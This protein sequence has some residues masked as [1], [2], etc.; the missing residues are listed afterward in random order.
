MKSAE[1]TASGRVEWSRIRKLKRA[2]AATVEFLEERRMMWGGGSGTLDQL[3]SSGTTGS[4][5]GGTMVSATP[6]YQSHTSTSG[7]GNVSIKVDLKNRDVTVGLPGLNTLLSDG[8]SSTTAA[9]SSLPPTSSIWWSSAAGLGNFYEDSG[10]PVGFSL[11]GLP[12]LGISS[13]NQSGRPVMLTVYDGN[14]YYSYDNVNTTDNFVP[15]GDDTARI[16]KLTVASRDFT[17]SSTPSGT[18]AYYI[19]E[20]GDGTRVYFDASSGAYRGQTDEYGNET[21]VVIRSSGDHEILEVNRRDGGL[22]ST[23]LEQTTFSY[24]GSWNLL[25]SKAF[26]RLQS[27]TLTEYQRLDFT[28]YQGNDSTGATNGYRG[29]LKLINLVRGGQ[30]VDSIYFRYHAEPTELGYYDEATDTY[31]H[32][33][34]MVFDQDAY[35]RLVADHPSDYDSG[36]LW[37]YSTYATTVFNYSGADIESVVTAGEGAYHDGTGTGQGTTTYTF[38]A[39]P[40]IG[41]APYGVNQPI[42]VVTIVTPDGTQTF[43]YLNAAGQILIE[44]VWN[45]VSDTN[46]STADTDRRDWITAYDYDANSRLIRVASP[47][48]VTRLL[49]GSY[50]GS[51]AFFK[52]SDSFAVDGVKNSA[53]VV[54][55]ATGRVDVY[56][57][58]SGTIGSDTPYNLVSAVKLSQG[59]NSST[60]STSEMT[61]VARTITDGNSNTFHAFLTSSVT[62]YP[63]EGSTSGARLTSN[64]YTFGSGSL[65]PSRVVVSAPSVSSSENGK[66]S[67]F[68]YTYDYNSLGLLTS[69]VDGENRTNTF[70]YDNPTRAILTSTVDAGGLALKTTYERDLFGRATKIV[71]PRY[72]GL[73][74]TNTYATFYVYDDAAHTVKTYE[75]WR[76]G[77]SNGYSGIGPVQMYRI[78]RARGYSEW[79]TY[80]PDL[81]SAYN[82]LTYTPTGTESISNIQSLVR[83]VRNTAQQV[84]SI[85]RYFTLTGTTYTNTSA[86]FGSSTTNYHSTTYGYDAYGRLDRTTLSTGTIYQTVYDLLGRVSEEKIGT[87]LANSRTTAVYQYDLGQAGNSLLTASIRYT[88]YNGSGVPD[89]DAARATE[90]GYDWRDRLVWK[91]EGSRLDTGGSTF[92]LLPAQESNA[93]TGTVWIEQLAYHRPITYYTYNNLDQVTATEMFDGDTQAISYS[94]GVPVKPSSGLLTAKS[95]YEYDAMGQLYRSSSWPVDGSGNVGTYAL[96]SDYWYDSLGNVLQ[97]KTPD[98]AAWK[99]TYD[100]AG[101]VTNAYAVLPGDADNSIFGTSVVAGSTVLEQYTYEYDK[102]SNLTLVTVRQRFHDASG[103]GALGT[104]ASTTSPK[105]RVSYTQYFYDP[106]SRLTDKVEVGTNGG[107]SYSA[108]SVVPSRSDTVLVTSYSYDAAGRTRDVTDP[109]GLITRY[110]YDMLGRTTEVTENYTTGTATGSSN[111]ITRYFYNGSNNVTEMWSIQPGTTN[112]QQTEFV[113]GVGTNTSSGIFSNELLYKIKHTDPSSGLASTSSSQQETYAYN[114]LGE[115]I[116]SVDRNGTI[117]QYEYDSLG[118]LLADR[119]TTAAA[120]VDTTVL[121]LSYSYDRAGRLKTAT[122][123]STANLDNLLNP[124]YTVNTVARSYDALGN[125]VKEDQPYG[126]VDYTYASPTATLNSSRLTGMSYGNTALTYVY[127]SGTDTAISRIS[128]IQ[129]KAFSNSAAI[130]LEE[131]DYLGLSNTVSLVRAE[132]NSAL[133]YYNSTSATGDAGDVYTGFD[134]F[135]R[136]ADQRWVTSYSGTWSNSDEYQ[137][138]YDRNSN[139]TSKLNVVSTGNSEYYAYDGLNRLT[140][141]QRG[142]LTFTGSTPTGTSGT[143]RSQSWTLDQLG[144]WESLT[145]NGTS[146]SRTHNKQNELVSVSG[147]GSLTYDNNGN[148]TVDESGNLLKWDAWGRL[149]EWTPH[150]VNTTYGNPKTYTYDALGRKISESNQGTLDGYAIRDSSFVYTQWWQVAVEIEVEDTGTQTTTTQGEYVWS[151]GP[152]RYIDGLV[153]KDSYVTVDD[154]IENLIGGGMTTDTVMGPTWSQRVYAQQDANWNVTSLQVVT[155][156]A[157]TTWTIA[158]RYQ[159]D[160]YGSRT[161]LTGSWGSRS[162]SSYDWVYGH[163]GLRY[164]TVSGLYDNR[165]RP[166]DPVQGRFT[167]QDPLGWP[168]GIS[169]FERQKSSPTFYTDSSGESS[170]PINRNPTDSGDAKIGIPNP[171]NPNE[172]IENHPEWPFGLGRLVEISTK[173]GNRIKTY[174]HRALY[175]CHYNILKL[176]WNGMRLS[177]WGDAVEVLLVDEYEEVDA[178]EAKEGDVLIIRNPA[179]GAITHSAVVVGYDENGFPIYQQKRGWGGQGDERVGNGDIQDRYPGNQ[180]VYRPK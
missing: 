116:L 82:T 42:E 76:L 174:G 109:K 14:D 43:D 73:A 41:S 87:T 167:S 143:T 27:S 117:H 55:T 165:A 124:T 21:T 162:S 16:R 105:A 144:N 115:V 30:T 88:K 101:R 85:D 163:Q 60:F 77:V 80:A 95:T 62:E 13:T 141:F 10:V 102:N 166:M 104:P 44:Q 31:S 111:R 152:G 151:A 92:A 51:A 168:E 1:G 172:P 155:R 160:P 11:V 159:Y 81:S 5:G 171:K 37:A 97:T 58:T 120:G 32:P 2:V 125:L 34:A 48:A 67:S 169:R 70:T 180:H 12:H 103:T 150:L 133:V 90:Y 64:S 179:T 137:Y 110:S 19:W 134:R 7:S 123:H 135:G 35:A 170:E 66:N 112:N 39:L 69:T 100:G 156:S 99:Y 40:N 38:T 75:G 130:N 136:V 86:Q 79:V 84:V 175:W 3:H 158:E 59:D 122:S 129:G 178:K 161:I 107:T 173:R 36:G 23:I 29:D 56:E 53:F 20:R 4:V 46:S 68:T 149:V 140:T 147:T 49:S 114:A 25:T 8:G 83:E 26:K 131:Y 52:V 154:G 96:T 33:L 93:G 142:T 139:P 153:L 18:V 6:G 126:S 22:S 146:V 15:R 24:D 9:G 61:Y 148:Q 98:G 89:R 108:G 128:A 45:Q 54:S 138:T 176:N 78:D 177:P 164:D 91:K 47:S 119:A 17:S 127:D 121:S 57:Y 113:Y 65:G 28:Y 94:S 50:S 106:L 118:R 71:S 132:S 74:T 145:T 157:P 63:V 72:D